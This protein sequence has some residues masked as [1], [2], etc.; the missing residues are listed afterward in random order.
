MT[1]CT[2]AELLKLSAVVCFLNN[3]L[4]SA[5]VSQKATGKPPV[6][7]TGT[8]SCGGGVVPPPEELFL[9]HEQAL[10]NKITRLKPK[11]F[12]F[13]FILNVFNPVGKPAHNPQ[14]SA[15]EN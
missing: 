12:A 10:S 15:A 8:L 1:G 11:K 4:L 13:V 5:F 2:A 14:T 7:D 6:P 3:C 9:P